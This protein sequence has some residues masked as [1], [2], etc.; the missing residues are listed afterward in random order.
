MVE[1]VES[2]ALG[3][4]DPSYTKVAALILAELRQPDIRI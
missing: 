2:P 3:A 4:G 1:L